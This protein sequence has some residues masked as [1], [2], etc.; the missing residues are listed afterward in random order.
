MNDVNR[1]TSASSTSLDVHI[2]CPPSAKEG[3][4]YDAATRL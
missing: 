2:S 4:L 1:F 3:F